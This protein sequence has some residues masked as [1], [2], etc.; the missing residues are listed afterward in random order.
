MS[1]MEDRRIQDNIQ[2]KDYRHSAGLLDMSEAVA[3]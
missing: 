1:E 2:G 3:V